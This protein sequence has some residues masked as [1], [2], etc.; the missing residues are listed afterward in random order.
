MKILN[1][2]SSIFLGLLSI[3]SI[4]QKQN[5]NT[6]QTISISDSVS[7]SYKK[8]TFNEIYKH[9]PKD[10]A[11]FANFTIQKDNLKWTSLAF[12]STIALIPFDQQLT[13]GAI[14]LG[15]RIDWDKDHSYNKVF[16]VLRIIPNDINSAVYYI[17]NGG[18][19]VLLSGTFY[20]IGK[21]NNDY[22][23]LTTSNELVEVLLSVGLVTQTI[24]RITGR[25]SPSEAI[26]SGNSGGHWT[27]FPSFNAFQSNTPNYD[28][29]PSGHIAT[30][31]A[32]ITVISTNYPEIK[33]IKP[34][35]YTLMGIIGFEMVSSK[36][37]WVSDYPIAILIGYVIGKNAAN[38]RILK[39][40]K[41]DITN[42][43]KEAKFKTDF[44][45]IFTNQYKTIGVTL[46]F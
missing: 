28:A 41:T 29:M 38:R 43:I 16:G 42:E 19:T 21:I 8:P 22:R 30:F 17:A 9:I 33:W 37:H 3:N 7:Y 2:I 14:D 26:L 6:I 24:K 20:A 44:N 31:M 25:Q 32:T 1:V 4:A 34:I 13:N 10:I 12:G 18:T 35:G 5:T 40:K 11:Q 27:P 23:A 46:T 45:F 36:V 39:T 15:H